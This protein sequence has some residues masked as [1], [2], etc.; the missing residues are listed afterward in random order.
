[1]IHDLLSFEAYFVDKFTQQHGIKT[2]IVGG[3]EEILE[4]Q[5]SSIRYPL[6][7]V[8][9]PTETL[10]IDGDSVFQTRLLTLINGG[11]LPRKQY[12]NNLNEMRK[13]LLTVLK[14]METNFPLVRK[15]AHLEY[16]ERYS[17]DDLHGAMVNISL[18]GDFM[19][20]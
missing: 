4:L 20:L 18:N 6:L 1:M 15:N 14:D 16:K 19:C 2:V 7:F 13:T 17:G 8:E 5:N 10:G 12:K 9:R 11:N 3:Y